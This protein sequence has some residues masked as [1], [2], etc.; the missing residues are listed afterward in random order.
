[1]SRFSSFFGELINRGAGSGAYGQPWTV[2]MLAEHLNRKGFVV[3]ATTLYR[4]Q[5]GD[6]H[7]RRGM[8]RDVVLAWELEDADI[9]RLWEVHRAG[10]KVKAPGQ[11]GNSSAELDE[12]LSCPLKQHTSSLQYNK[13]GTAKKHGSNQIDSI[14]IVLAVL[15]FRSR[16]EGFFDRFV[17]FGLCEEIIVR[18]SKLSSIRVVSLESVLGMDRSTNSIDTIGTR[19]GVTLVVSGHVQ[20]RSES[21][22]IY[23]SL[24]DVAS[25]HVMWGDVVSIDVGHLT[26]VSE[27]V[28]EHIQ[29]AL[30]QIIGIETPKVKTVG[31]SAH[32]PKAYEFL[33]RAVGLIMSAKKDD[34]PVAYGL[35]Q[36]AIALDSTCAPAYAWLGYLRWYRYFRFWESS[37]ESLDQA[38]VDADRALAI[39][40]DCTAARFTKVRVYWDLGKHW[41]AVEE[42]ALAITSAPYLVDS[43]LAFARALHNA[44]VA[45]MALPWTKNALAYDPANSAARKLLLWNHLMLG[46]FNE[47]T[48]ISSS[49]LQLNPLDANTA[50]AISLSHLLAGDFESAEAMAREGLAI[51]RTDASL[52]VLLG[53]IRSE[54][55]GLTEARAVWLE[56]SAIVG[57]HVVQFSSHWRARAWLAILLGASQSP[58]WQTEV[59]AISL[60]APRN[61]YLEYRVACAAAAAEENEAALRWLRS[62]IEYGFCSIQ[63]MRQEQVLFWRSASTSKAYEEITTEL[64]ARIDVTKARY[65][66]ISP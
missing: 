62:A 21:I 52:W 23:Q 7:P 65:L 9:D 48:Q 25:G 64:Q 43:I 2:P 30:K 8:L 11:R 31:T 34:L 60:G 12:R 35:L 44:G 49:F 5:N 42:G 46:H 53:Y 40:G 57:A 4:W 61:G 63:L 10:I 3:T 19:L 29:G 45:E 66:A 15:P 47:V 59:R 18:L 39:D 58:A 24:I 22:Q 6:V 55:R 32:D 28:A 56:G 51:S 1:M 50:W 17:S 20:E 33:L 54:A 14:P 36:Q 13:V 41:E 26:K 16:A 37:F 27:L 38:L